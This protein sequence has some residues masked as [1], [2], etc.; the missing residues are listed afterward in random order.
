MMYLTSGAPRQGFASPLRALDTTHQLLSTTGLTRGAASESGCLVDVRCR[1]GGSVRLLACPC[2]CESEADLQPSI[3]FRHPDHCSC[4]YR[5]EGERRFLSRL[6]AV[7]L[8][9]IHRSLQ[10]FFPI[11][12]DGMPATSRS[13]LRSGR[14]PRRPPFGRTRCQCCTLSYGI[15]VAVGELREVKKVAICAQLLIINTMTT[16]DPWM[17]EE[18]GQFCLAVNDLL[19]DRPMSVAKMKPAYIGKFLTEKDDPR[20]ALQVDEIIGSIIGIDD[21]ELVAIGVNHG[22]NRSE[23]REIVAAAIASVAEAI[24]IM[25]ARES[26]YQAA[27]AGDRHM[28]YHFR[29]QALLGAVWRKTYNPPATR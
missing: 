23:V 10:F 1:I 26:A 22:F 24:W 5:K 13:S 8:P 12:M 18:A 21:S 25:A 27:S 9:E 6:P 17:R 14:R 2:N 20:L 7:L 4:D 29:C 19:T 11:E 3:Y 16:T 28:M 15:S